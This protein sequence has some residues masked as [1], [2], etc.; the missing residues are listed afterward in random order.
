MC[1]AEH[2]GGSQ[3]NCVST[4]VAFLPGRS[5][6][7]CESTTRTRTS[8]VSTRQG[9]TPSTCRTRRLEICLDCHCN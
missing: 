8:L 5:L 7:G 3:E 2:F 4:T 6:P 1:H 9:P